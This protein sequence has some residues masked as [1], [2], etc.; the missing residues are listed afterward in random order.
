MAGNSGRP[1]IFAFVLDNLPA[2]VFASLSVAAPK[3]DSSYLAGGAP[4]LTYLGKARRPLTLSLWAQ[5]GARGRVVFV[6]FPQSA[7]C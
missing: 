4:C 5:M 6:D 7:V 3:S 1:R 2:T